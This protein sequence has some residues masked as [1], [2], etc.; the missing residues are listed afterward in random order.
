MLDTA[1][2]F[3][4]IPDTEVALLATPQASA[5]TR[6]LAEALAHFCGTLDPRMAA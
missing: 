3:P 1:D 4:P 5:A 2:G 6:R